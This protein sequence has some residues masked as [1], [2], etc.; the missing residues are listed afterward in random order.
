MA[1]VRETLRA[2]ARTAG[3]QAGRAIENFVYARKSLHGARVR[4]SACDRLPKRRAE[5]QPQTRPNCHSAC[6]QRRRP[7][8]KGSVVTQQCCRWLGLAL[9][10]AG[11]SLPAAAQMLSEA[12]RRA[13]LA[14]FRTAFLDRDRAYTPAAREQALARLAELEALPGDI[15]STRF[16]LALSTIAALADN[17]HSGVGTGLRVQRSNRVEIRLVPFGTD[18]HVLRARGPDADLLGA[19]LVAIDDVPV[20]LLRAAAHTLSG[21]LPAWRDRV[22]PFLFESPEQLQALGLIQAADTAVYRF[23]TAQGSQIE[24]RL[25][26]APPSPERPRAGT[27]RL[28]LPEVLPDVL[29]WRG[30][31]DGSQ[32]PWALRDA[33]L[34]QRWRRAPEIDALV[35]E[36]RWMNNTADQK[37]QDF[38][39][40]VQAQAQRDPARHLVLDLRQ[41]GGGDLTQV[42]DFAERLPSRVPGRIFAL[43]SP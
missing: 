25:V 22:A 16:S 14:Q 12:A 4:L 43:T 41:N 35:V 27:E 11:L 39:A 15:S 7:V 36:M 24:R 38:F 3:T 29:G 8:L 23:I 13:D 33:N 2:A 42:R 17:G 1:R 40:E 32:A 9:C 28:L 21:G 26:A 19:R 6:L 37:L 18:F 31:L 20:E 5:T 34:R 10:L 30:L